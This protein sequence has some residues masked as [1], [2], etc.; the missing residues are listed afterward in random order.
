M[1]LQKG[2]SKPVFLVASV[3]LVFM[4]ILVYWA[5]ASSGIQGGVESAFNLASNFP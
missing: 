5:S 3:V 2:Y 4:F 1:E